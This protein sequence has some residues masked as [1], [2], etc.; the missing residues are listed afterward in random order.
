MLK[1]LAVDLDDMPKL[2]GSNPKAKSKVYAN[3]NQKKR[4]GKNEARMRGTNFQERLAADER[5]SQQTEQVQANT[6]FGRELFIPQSLQVL[7]DI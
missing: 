1:R 2:K 3:I 7:D 5:Q 4:P 6:G